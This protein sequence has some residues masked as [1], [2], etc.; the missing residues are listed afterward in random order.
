MLKIAILAEHSAPNVGWYGDVVF[1]MLER[2]PDS[3]SD[4]A[5]CRVVQVA[6][7]FEE[8]CSGIEKNRLQSHAVGKSTSSL[9]SFLRTRAWPSLAATVA[10]NTWPN[11]L[12]KGFQLALIEGSNPQCT[13]AA[14]TFNTGTPDRCKPGAMTIRST[15]FAS[16]PGLTPGRRHRP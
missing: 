12:T 13:M 7:G 8:G 4:E 6:A 15:W 5:R 10:P 3:V 16:L 11:Y 14:G 2:A 1:R 9:W